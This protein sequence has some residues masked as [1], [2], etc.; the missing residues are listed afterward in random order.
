MVALG[1]LIALVALVVLVVLVACA[2]GVAMMVWPRRRCA[3]LEFSPH[4]SEIPFY[5]LTEASSLTQKELNL[6]VTMAA[7]WTNFA[8]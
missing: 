7:Y 1:S 4:S 5:F 8:R 2:C 3:G 6:S